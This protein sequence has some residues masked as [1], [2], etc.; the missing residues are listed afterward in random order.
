MMLCVQDQDSHLGCAP[1]DGTAWGPSTQL[2]D[3]TG[4]IKN[5]PFLFLWS[6]VQ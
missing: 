4:E 2:T 6:Y 1:W 3:D 5:Q